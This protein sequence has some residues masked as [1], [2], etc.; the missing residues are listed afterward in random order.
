MKILFVCRSFHNMA[1]GVERM[2]CA[3]M[4]A[5][6]KRGHEISLLTWDTE[7]STSFYAMD[8]S[9]SWY[10]LDL[11]DPMQK[12]NFTTRVKRAIKIR[13]YVKQ[14]EPDVIIA[15]QEGAYLA[16]WLF[17]LF[18]GIPVIAAERN[19]PGRFEYLSIRKYKNIFYQSFRFS[20]AVT[21]QLDSYKDEYPEYLQKKI[22]AIPNPVYP[23]ETIANPGGVEN[24]SKILLSVGRLGYQK[25]YQVLIKAFLL[26]AETYKD[27]KLLI[28]GEGED[29]SELESLIKSNNLE[30][31]ISLPGTSDKI[32]D[33]YSKAHLF[34]LA[35]RWEG[36]PNALAEAMSHG[37]P[38][39]GFSQCDGVNYL[40]EKKKNG[41]LAEGMN[42]EN[43]LAKALGALMSDANERTRMGKMAVEMMKVYEPEIIFNQ[44][45]QLFKNLTSK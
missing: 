29:R 15:F 13:S 6:R 1:G 33:I 3:L 26:L 24:S 41:L 4:E 7:S 43:T 8:E 2:A 45:D 40:I 19:S 23:A 9:I 42:N 36:F 37:L 14:K 11:G 30:S 12:A 21:V 27:W 16:A 38:C 34:C 22:V 5:M 18:S 44:W 32:E 39:V 31:R 35:S 20:A 17:N 28:I 10:R 25:N